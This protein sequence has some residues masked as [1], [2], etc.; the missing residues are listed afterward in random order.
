[1]S[2]MFPELLRFSSSSRLLEMVPEDIRD[3]HR[4]STLA[5]SMPLDVS[6]LSHRQ[7]ASQ[8]NR[9]LGPHVAEVQ[10]P[11]DIWEDWADGEATSYNDK[12]KHT[13]A[14]CTFNIS[15]SDDD[16]ADDNESYADFT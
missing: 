1:M 14:S 6:R 12:D 5:A 13:H 10:Q 15:D 16:S 7:T 2:R 3:A 4:P 8:N 9:Y 11:L